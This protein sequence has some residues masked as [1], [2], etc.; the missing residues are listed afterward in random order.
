MAEYGETKTFFFRSK[1]QYSKMKPFIFYYLV[2]WFAN[3][4]AHVTVHRDQ[5]L[6]I[7]PNRCTN[8]SN[9]LF[10]NET[11]HVSGSCCVHHQEFSTVHT[12]MYMSYLYAVCTVENSWWLTEE[13]FGTCKVSF[14][15]KNVEKLVH[16]CGSIINKFANL[17]QNFIFY[18][19][20]LSF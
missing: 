18:H 19:S 10:W 16:L 17:F 20:S 14:Q 7:K 3:F 12:A 2:H 11:L 15:N 1:N 4:D 6:I 5:F 9:F 13:L 8:F